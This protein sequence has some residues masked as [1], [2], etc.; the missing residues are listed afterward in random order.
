M[1][2]RTPRGKPPAPPKKPGP[3]V[4]ESKDD[5]DVQRIHMNIV[6]REKGEPGEGFEPTPWW[7]WT[8]SVL[9]LFAMGFYLGRF[10]WTFSAVAHEVEQPNIA[11]AP[12]A[13][14]EVK[15]DV[16][17]AGVCQACHQSTGLGIPGQY[18]PLA[19]S[20]WLSHDSETPIRIVLFGLQGEVT[21]KGSP[22][23]NRMPQLHDKLSSAEIA[24]VLTYVRSSW[25]NKAQ[26]ITV[27]Q[28]DSIR[29]KTPVR[30]PWTSA[31]LLDLRKSHAQ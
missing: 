8:A 14:R 1:T 23:N 13:K 10:S 29:Q 28:V 20:E 9:L 4:D 25:G 31:E 11:N 27:A 21:V 7:V 17:Y 15:G 18:P 19:G 5:I 22:F 24:S 16:I 3:F 12:M 26:S 6:A 2:L 30:G